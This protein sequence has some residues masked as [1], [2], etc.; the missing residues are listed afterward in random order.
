MWRQ[1]D[2][3]I[4]RGRRKPHRARLPWQSTTGLVMMLER[5]V[6]AADLDWRARRHRIL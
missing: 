5:M 3:R 4:V 2:R 1:Q 6:R